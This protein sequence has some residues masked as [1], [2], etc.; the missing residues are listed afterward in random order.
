MH[1]GLVFL[2]IPALVLVVLS[3]L[4][5]GRVALVG[6][7]LGLA[8]TFGTLGWDADGTGFGILLTTGLALAVMV[9]TLVQLSRHL[10]RGAPMLPLFA[11]LVLVAGLLF[12]VLRRL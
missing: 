8:A 12:F 4:P 3:I 1:M 7:G 10:R 5:P 9:A 6:L 2:G 11:I